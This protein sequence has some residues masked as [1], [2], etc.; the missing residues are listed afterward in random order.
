MKAYSVDS[1]VLDVDEQNRAFVTCTIDFRDGEDAPLED[2]PLEVYELGP[3]DEREHIS[4]VR[5][6]EL[7]EATFEVIFDILREARKDLQFV[8]GDSVVTQTVLLKTIDPKI[9][10]RM[11]EIRKKE[12]RE[13]QRKREQERAEQQK[14]EREE[15]LKREQER[16]EQQKKELKREQEQFTEQ[17]KRKHEER[18]KREEEQR[19]E[20]QKRKHEEGLKWQQEQAEKR[21]KGEE[22]YRH[23]N[24]RLVL[25]RAKLMFDEHNRVGRFYTGTGYVLI[26]SN[27]NV[28]TMHEF[29]SIGPFNKGNMPYAVADAVTL[30]GFKMRITSDGR[31]VDSKTGLTKPLEDS[32][33]KRKEIQWAL[34]EKSA[35]PLTVNW[36][37][38]FS[39]G[40]DQGRRE[41][42]LDGLPALRFGLKELLPPPV[43]IS[44]RIEDRNLTLQF[45]NVA[46][47]CRLFRE[48]TNLSDHGW[49]DRMPWKKKK[50]D[51]YGK[52]SF[53]EAINEYSDEESFSVLLSRSKYLR[54]NPN[55]PP[56]V[57]GLFSHK[58]Y[59]AGRDEE[60]EAAVMEFKRSLDLLRKEGVSLDS[61]FLNL[62]FVA[63][64]RVGDSNV[65]MSE[66]DLVGDYVTGE[67]ETFGD[68]LE[69]KFVELYHLELEKALEAVGCCEKIDKA[70]WCNDSGGMKS[71]DLTVNTQQVLCKNVS[72]GRIYAQIDQDTMEFP[73]EGGTITVVP[74]NPE[75]S[76]MVSLKRK[77]GSEEQEIGQVELKG[78][79]VVKICFSFLNV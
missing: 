29:E 41:K 52:I 64:G 19:A 46:Q 30:S 54:L 20:Q 3:D 76:K 8:F 7:G 2:A 65:L 79:R 48:K 51:W 5:T 74:E 75:D 28:M 47:L 25:C 33:F 66:L 23:C 62:Y 14:K 45:P 69:A 24:E 31:K 32:D 57:T 18:L 21:K 71:I 77:Y 13:E 53:C 44:S 78:C 26:D 59:F 35:Q 39:G 16:A 68:Y 17:Q 15:G 34:P 58:K 42:S 49:W 72:D 67:F 40:E 50:T 11:E 6:D 43:E 1:Q 4:N 63:L 9:M 10:K 36:N 27:G 60:V 73:I 70:D 38:I 55:L 22:D 61:R 56:E 37:E 12:E